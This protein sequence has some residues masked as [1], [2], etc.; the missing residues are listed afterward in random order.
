MNFRNFFVED[1]V[2]D[3]T[4]SKI[5]F[6]HKMLP[7]VGIAPGTFCDP[8]WL[9]PDWANSASVNLGIFNFTF[10]DAPIDF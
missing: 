9:L 6:L 1:D 8:L 10:V 5:N 2:E 3:D 4:K 7:P